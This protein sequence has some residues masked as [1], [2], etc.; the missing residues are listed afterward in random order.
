MVVVLNGFTISRQFAAFDSSSLPVLVSPLC[1][2]NAG[3]AKKI[4]AFLDFPLAYLQRIFIVTDDF[5][6]IFLDCHLFFQDLLP[7]DEPWNP[8]KIRQ[9]PELKEFLLANRLHGG[10]RG[11]NVVSSFLLKAMGQGDL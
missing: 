5:L 2:P 3:W 7:K 6:V 1:S 4:S 8:A 9:L 11:M 10:N